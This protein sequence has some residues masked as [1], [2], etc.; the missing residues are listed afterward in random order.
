MSQVREL[1]QSM[2]HNEQ[3]L[4]VGIFEK[5]LAHKLTFLN[6]PPLFIK[7]KV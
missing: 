3:G 5:T 7:G 1:S 4:V 6:F 2:T